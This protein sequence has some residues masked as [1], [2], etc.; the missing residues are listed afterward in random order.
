[1]FAVVAL[2][3]MAASAGAAT[4]WPGDSATKTAD[5]TNVFGTNLS[6]L[7]F[8]SPNVVWAVKNGPSTLYRLVPSGSTWKVDQKRSLKFKDGQG[9]PDAEGVVF[10]PD[11]LFVAVERDN[12]NGDTSSPMILKYGTGSAATAEWALGGMPEV[13]PND[14]PEAIS[15]L[16]DSYLTSNG[17]KDSSGKTYNPADYPGHGSGL[18]AVGLEATGEVYVYALQGT[19]KLIT[20]FASG[21]KQVM[22]LEFDGGKLWAV[23]DNNCSGRSTTL[24]VSGGNFK[25]SA[26]YD[27]PSKLPN[28]NLEGFAISP[29]CVNGKKTVLW[30]DD[31]NTSGHALRSGSLRCGA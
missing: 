8:E 4:T 7:S 22:D 31:D 10:T 21:H 23:C 20:K 29:S 30:S 25:V 14:G 18:F 5:G 9:D 28:V 3:M 17:F 12:N 2:G 6:G 11:G 1:M 16:P 26:T 13:D 19:A 27:R 24:T 15:W